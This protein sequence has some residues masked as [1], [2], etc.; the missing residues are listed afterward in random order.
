M[1]L[2]K[3]SFKGIKSIYD[4]FNPSD[5]QKA[6]NESYK[7]ESLKLVKE[8]AKKDAKAKYKKVKKQ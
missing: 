6:Y 4:T 5:E 2:I 3:K 1:S 8:Q 7:K